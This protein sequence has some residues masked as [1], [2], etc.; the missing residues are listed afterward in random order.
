MIKPM[1]TLIRIAI[2]GAVPIFCFA[3]QQAAHKPD[4]SLCGSCHD[5]VQKISGTA[6]ANVPC[7][8]CHPKH[9]EYPHPAGIPK[10]ACASCHARIAEGYR[11]GV[12]GKAVASGNQGAPECTTCHGNAHEVAVATSMAFRKNIPDTCGMCHSDVAEQFK[13]SVH[14]KALAEG[15]VSAPV[16]NDCH[17]EH[18]IIPPKNQ[19]SPVNAAHI[20]ETCAQ[21][22]GN[23]ILARR[24]GIPADRIT[25]FDASYHGLALKAGNET[26]ANCASCHGIHNILRSSD[27]RSTTNAKNLP[28]TCGK[29]HPGAGERFALG[30][31]HQ[32]QGATEP[33]AVAWVRSLY[34]L[35]IPLTIGLML[36]HNGG[37]WI[38]KLVRTYRG[39]PLVRLPRTSGDLR[40]FRFERIQHALAASSFIILCWTGFALK[41]PEQWWARPLLVFEPAVNTRGLLHRIAAVVLTSVA[42]AHILSLMADRRLREHWLHMVPR[43]RDIRDSIASMAYNLG[44]TH[45]RP[46][47]PAHSYIE[48]AEYWAMI[49]GT[50]VM[51]ATGVLLWANSWVLRWLPKTVL[52]FSTAVHFYEAIL[53]GLAIVVWHFYSVILDPDVYPLDTAWL[54]G[55]SVRLREAE[56]EGGDE[57]K[58]TE[59]SE[60][61]DAG[62]EGLDIHLRVP[63]DKT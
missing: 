49:W 19:N 47:L 10:P 2:L 15:V 57:E 45:E 48:K 24:F 18:L 9:E 62:Q 51:G 53:A 31:I 60:S 22:H 21:C 30:P 37:D 26:V 27:P 38:R 6:H 42:V 43:I 50:F 52:D 16:C 41:Y 4:N 59:S 35:A 25:T 8:S 34:L 13:S 5:Q 29:C 3:Q 36:L 11:N 54:T 33:V 23:V 44:F 56:F 32:S 39:V 14:G 1:G 63:R 58:K 20:R 40:M 61:A 7:A 46:K 28:T 55:H 12:H 17:G